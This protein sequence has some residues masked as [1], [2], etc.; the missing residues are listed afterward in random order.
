M[1]SFDIV[2]QPNLQEVDNAIQQTKKEISQRFDFKG[3]KAEVDWDKKK[4]IIL[5][6]DD[7]F[8]LKALIDILQSKFAK[9]KVSIKNM[10]YGT[11]EKAS[12]GAVRQTITLQQG[13]PSEKAKT[14]ISQIK[15]TG[16]KIQSQNQ[17]EQIR[18][19]GKKKDDLQQVMQVVKK[20]DLGLDLE[21][22]NFRD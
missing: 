19:S 21:F 3:S 22:S 10:V 2:V 18:V 14:I 20:I 1:P 12:Q 17:D 9:R 8:K 7:E 5:V 11:L 4:E 13:I 15:E 16:F 6:A